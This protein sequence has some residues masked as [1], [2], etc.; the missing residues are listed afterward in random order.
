MDLRK[1]HKILLVLYRL[2]KGKKSNLKFEDIVVALYKK[3]PEEFNLK[4]YPEYPDADLIRRPLYRFRDEGLLDARNMVFVFTNK[5]L[6]IAGKINN[7]V[8]KKKVRSEQV[9]DRYI[10]SEI[11]RILSTNAYKLFIRN[12]QAKI[13]DTDFF[14]YIGVSV[15]ADKKVF[16]NR[17]NVLNEMSQVILNAQQDRYKKLTELH[18]LLKKKFRKEI[19]YYLKKHES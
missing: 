16:K 2:A 18:S 3:Y 13:L 11:R 14:D 19:S 7:R 9:F 1:K 12:E 10:E 4:G 6:E 8:G 17:I 5:G 15:R